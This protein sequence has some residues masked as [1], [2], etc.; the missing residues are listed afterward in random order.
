[1]VLFRLADHAQTSA[2]FDS[3]RDSHLDHAPLGHAAVALARLAPALEDPPEAV[4]VV[5]AHDSEHPSFA[6]PGRDADL[7][8]PLAGQALVHVGSGDG[9]GS[10]A[11]RAL[12][13][14]GEVHLALGAPFGLDLV[15]LHLGEHPR[16]RPLLSRVEPSVATP[17]VAEPVV[18]E[19]GGRLGEDAVGRR[20]LPEALLR[21]GL[22]GDVGMELTRA[23]AKGSADLL[24]AG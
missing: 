2:V 9:A 20:H 7:A 19:S 6:E 3:G 14:G 13:P 4:A 5:T 10:A 17:P 1:M 8:A 22:L 15:D 21:L 12:F 23:R 11:D 24:V 18:E 16:L